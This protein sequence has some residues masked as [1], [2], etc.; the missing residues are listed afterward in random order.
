MVTGGLMDIPESVLSIGAA[1][2]GYLAEKSIDKT[3]S[4]VISQL[5]ARRAETFMRRLA[6][7]LEESSNNKDPTTPADLLSRLDRNPTLGE[8]IFDYWRAANLSRSRTIGPKVLACLASR[9]LLE[10]R[11]PNGIELE[12]AD[13]AERCNDTELLGFFE[14]FNDRF[15]GGANNFHPDHGGA[16]EIT[17]DARDQTWRQGLPNTGPL[18]LREWFGAWAVIFEALGLL[19]QDAQ[20]KSWDYDADCERHID[21]PGTVHETTWSLL[22]N[23]SCLELFALIKLSRNDQ[24]PCE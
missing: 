21:S 7:L 18:N 13:A 11:E 14:F 5:K 24:M 1:A 17:S 16:V 12:C 15:A 8:A 23:P 20:T 9:T 2:G 22:L 19:E 6:S 3:L 4:S 10:R